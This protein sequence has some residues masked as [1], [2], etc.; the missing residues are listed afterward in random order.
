MKKG[1]FYRILGLILAVTMLFGLTGFT[2]LAPAGTS[3]TI[4]YTMDEPGQ[5]DQGDQPTEP[6]EPTEPGK[7][8][9]G[10]QPT[11]PGQGD[12]GEQGTPSD[13]VNVTYETYEDLE[14]KTKNYEAE[15]G[16]YVKIFKSTETITFVATP[17]AETYNEYLSVNLVAFANNKNDAITVT[18][19]NNGSWSI[20]LDLTKFN[21]ED[22]IKVTAKLYG[23]KSMSQQGFKYDES[24]QEDGKWAYKREITVNTFGFDDGEHVL[25]IDNCVYSEKNGKLVINEEV[26]ADEKEIVVSATG[27]VNEISVTATADATVSKIDRTA[28]SATLAYEI[29]K[30][31]GGKD[32]Y[33]GTVTINEDDGSKIESV[34]YYS[35]ID[36]D[37]SKPEHADCDPINSLI[38][39]FNAD[40]YQDFIS[41]NW[42]LSLIHI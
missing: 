7:G 34:M 39:K 40:A 25:G 23:I 26:S 14:V 3:N 42:D 6:N 27:T 20:V 36:G 2:F 19:N 30:I 38:Y 28:P 9:Q 1:I 4:G 29:K 11:E 18:K 12:Q 21:N 31:T 8:D 37:I 16:E 22:K 33:H 41:N 24:Y 35:I 5:G 32:E 15:P 10:E 13:I 17:N